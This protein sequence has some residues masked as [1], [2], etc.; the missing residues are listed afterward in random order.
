VKRIPESSGLETDAFSKRGR[1][2]HTAFKRAGQAKAAKRSYNRRF[3]KA[4]KK[5]LT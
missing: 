2:I 1:R 4:W 3:R 5:E